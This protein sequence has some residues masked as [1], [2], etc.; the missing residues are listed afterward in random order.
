MALRFTLE[1]VQEAENEMFAICLDCGAEKECCEPDVE[2][3]VCDECGESSVTGPL[4]ILVMGL[5]D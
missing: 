2:G 4:N 3:V 5:V 1:H